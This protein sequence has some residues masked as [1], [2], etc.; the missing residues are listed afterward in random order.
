MPTGVNSNKPTTRKPRD[1]TVTIS[2]TEVKKVSPPDFKT[3]K[4][5]AQLTAD[6]KAGYY[7]DQQKLITTYINKVDINNAEQVEFFLAVMYRKE[8]QDIAK[9]KLNLFARRLS[10]DQSVVFDK[11]DNKK[12]I[13]LTKLARVGI[14]ETTEGKKKIAKFF[15][16]IDLDKVMAYGTYFPPSFGLGDIDWNRY[17]EPIDFFTATKVTEHLPDFYSQLLNRSST[18]KNKTHFCLL[19][20]DMTCTK[21][22][23]F[24]LSV[25]DR[26]LIERV[27]GEFKY[28]SD[29]PS[30]DDFRD[31]GLYDPHR[32]L[33]PLIN[34]TITFK[35]EP[36]TLG[37]N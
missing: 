37:I 25:R 7:D 9:L 5:L 34:D 1:R 11:K 30:A 17:H 14:F 24:N 18:Y 16:E 19:L 3:G 6:V 36:I 27:L 2:R 31:I 35:V 26:Q 32:R 20:C 29:F 4:N 15:E 12:I 21:K 28:Y 13:M 22:I 33:L 10:M 8:L 23:D